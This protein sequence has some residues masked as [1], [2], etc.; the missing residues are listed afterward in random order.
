MPAYAASSAGVARSR[1]GV[2]PTPRSTAAAT[3]TALARGSRSEHDRQQLTVGELLGA[4]GGE[5][6]ARAG[7]RFQ[8][9]YG[10]HALVDGNA[11]AKAE[12]ETSKGRDVEVKGSVDTV[13]GAC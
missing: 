2:P 10:R 7:V 1:P 6:L 4:T 3:S 12:V 5:P 13:G 11:C 8:G 9:R